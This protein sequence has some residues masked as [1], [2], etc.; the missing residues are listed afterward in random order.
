MLFQFPAN[1]QGTTYVPCVVRIVEGAG[2]YWLEAGKEQQKAVIDKDAFITFSQ[3]PAKNAQESADTIREFALCYGM[4]TGDTSESV[5]AWLKQIREMRLA[6]EAWQAVST[7]DASWLRKNIHL[8]TRL[9]YDQINDDGSR[10]H[11]KRSANYILDYE[12]D[13]YSIRMLIAGELK[14][15]AR[16]KEIN[17]YRGLNRSLTKKFNIF[18][19]AAQSLVVELINNNLMNLNGDI[20]VRQNK[21]DFRLFYK[22]RHL[23]T[24]L[25]LQFASKV[26]QSGKENR[27]QCQHCADWYTRKRNT[28]LY[29]ST[30]CRMAAHRQANSVAVQP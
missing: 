11:I 24:M 15:N 7:N 29:C 27:V 9:A 22:P 10:T 8:P 1:A 12:A 14:N 21:K 19:F 3:L 16:K 30:R 2:E 20:E 17:Q 5:D 25:W 28:S 13:G 4:L 23:Q 6:I 18:A 26:F